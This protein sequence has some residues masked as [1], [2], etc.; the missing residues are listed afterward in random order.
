MPESHHEPTF[1]LKVAVRETG[2]KPDTLRAWERRYGLPQ[3][4]RSEGGHRLYSQR[5]IDTLK[6]L[7]ARQQEGM[8]ISRATELWFKL[9]EDGEDPLH[10]SEPGGAQSP[11]I[12]HG[13]NGNV[14][15]E[16]CEKWVTAC[17]QFNEPV[18]EQ[19]LHQ[20]FSLYQPEIV[21]VELLLKGI[22]EIGNGWYTG[23]I[24]VQQEHFASEL[25]IRRVEAMIMAS[26]PPYRPK[27]ILL[28]CPPEENHVFSQL[29]LNL[30]LRRRGWDVLYLGANVPPERLQLTIKTVAPSLVVMSAQQL[31]T[32]ATLFQMSHLLADIQM[33]LAYGGLIF[34]R[35][36]GLRPQIPGYFLGEKIENAVPTI[37]KWLTA[38]TSLKSKD[39]EEPVSSRYSVALDHYLDGQK[40]IELEVWRLLK[41]TDFYSDELQQSYNYLASSIASA[42]RLGDINFLNEDILWAEKLLCHRDIPSATLTGLLEIYHR[43]ALAHLDDRAQ[44]VIDWLS[45][46]GNLVGSKQNKL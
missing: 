11:P 41:N 34:N 33:P 15:E 2:L 32:A 10:S 26:P 35:M 45:T 40:A 25:A 6:W 12:V 30:F 38:A 36:P 16:L 8:S 44:I 3:P 24:T 29:I 20:A 28:A 31:T 4:S 17:V 1:N 13:A 42:L 43:A 18:A 14:L 39:A 19:I 22:V 9:I 23:E 37:E 27:R 5:D 46:A 21:V 7:V